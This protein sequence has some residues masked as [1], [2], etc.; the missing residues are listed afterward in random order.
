MSFD[1]EKKLSSSELLEN[2]LRAYMNY[3]NNLFIFLVF[4]LFSVVTHAASFDCAKAE[5]PI[6]KAICVDPDLSALDEKLAVVYA[7]EFA[8]NPKIKEQQ[9][10][11]LRSLK[12]CNG[13]VSILV[14]CLKPMFID[15]INILDKQFQSPSEQSASNSSVVQSQQSINVT[16]QLQPGPSTNNVKTVKITSGDDGSSLSSA[17]VAVVIAVILAMTFIVL[18]KKKKIPENYDQQETVDSQNTRK[19]QSIAPI[20]PIAPIDEPLDPVEGIYQRALELLEAGSLSKAAQLLEDSANRGHLNS[21]YQLGKLMLEQSSAKGDSHYEAGMA[22]MKKAASLKHPKALLF[23]NDLDEPSSNIEEAYIDDDCT[24]EVPD[25]EGVDKETLGCQMSV[26]I[27]IINDDSWF[28]NGSTGSF[29]LDGSVRI[30]SEEESIDDPGIF[31]ENYDEM[32]LYRLKDYD[33]ILFSD[34]EA[35]SEILAN[36][37]N[38]WQ[39]TYTFDFS[40]AVEPCEPLSPYSIVSSRQVKVRFIQFG[41][42]TECGYRVDLANDLDLSWLDTWIQGIKDRGE[43]VSEA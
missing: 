31:L 2:P 40:E 25:W 24:N 35:I 6:D 26:L 5:R 14:S 21:Q 42:G 22:W 43:T 41:P 38:M 39:F 30:E 11:W 3:K 34:T 13:D 8:V 18:K 29:I 33:G 15:R 19:V 27:S 32:T 17:L 9:R 1:Y 28:P 20:A 4:L 7:K 36:E 37:D 12:Q 16:E 23:L 10:E